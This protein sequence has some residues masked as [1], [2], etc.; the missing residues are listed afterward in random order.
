MSV[1]FNGRR[2][3]T[4]AVESRIDDAGMLPRSLATGNVLAIVGR[5]SG[6]EPNKALRLRSPT[7]ARSL[8]RS[9]EGLRAAEMAFAPSAETRGP[10]EIVFVRVNPA[11]RSTLNLKNASNADVIALSS[12][13]YGIYT[14]TISVQVESGSVS[15]KRVTTRLGNRSHSADNIG[16]AAA[17]VTYSGAADPATVTV[18]NTQLTLTAGAS[19]VID[20][21]TYPT[22]QQLV[23][24]INAEPDWT[25]SVVAGSANTPSLN[26]LDHVSA[27]NAKVALTLRAD[28]QAIVDWLNSFAESYVTAVRVSGAGTVPANLSTT[29]LAGGTDGTVTNESWSDALEVLMAEDVQYI[30]PL[31]S[32]PSVW[33]MTDAH[34]MYMSTMG[35]MERRAFVGGALS[36]DLDAA[37]AN[38]SLINSDRTAYVAPG[39]YNPGPDGALTLYEPYFLAALIAAGFS[40]LNPGEAM[41]NRSLRVMGLEYDLLATSD[42]DRAIDGGVTAV[43]RTPRGN[44][45]VRSVS[46]WLSD[47]KFN[48][49]EV[50][51]GVATD[52]TARSVRDALRGFVGAK[53]N[54]Q[55]RALAVSRSQSV[56]RELSRPEPEGPGVLA[57]DAENPPYRN[58]SAE[59]EEDI[60]R[61]SFE[62]SPVIPINYVLVT[63]SV[64]PYSSVQQ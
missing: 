62:C 27:A 58:I 35:Q 46:T 32:E 43:M 19:I 53:A 56:L 49:V 40:G 50:S 55:S 1:F 28:L 36:T 31:S 8:L 30:V 26:G 24:R 6:G 10:A 5:S 13:D 42:T 45:V 48:R 39:I 61:V 16:R 23:D 20:L 3:T 11:T 12:T 57:G 64:A 60:L 15:G 2:L 33:A 34:C 14:Q 7:H 17:V 21:A 4:P 52:F 51:C 29:F 9:G 38:A 22:V 41:T 63:I 54:P 37:I 44:R 18:S 47:R 59:I 25:A